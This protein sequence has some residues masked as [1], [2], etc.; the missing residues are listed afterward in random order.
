MDTHEIVLSMQNICK[1][2]VGIRALDDVSIDFR[3][4]EVHA[5][6]GENGAGKS[7]LIKMISGFRKTCIWRADL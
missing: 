3:K 5:L 2:Y 1:R 7:T 4:G 6:V